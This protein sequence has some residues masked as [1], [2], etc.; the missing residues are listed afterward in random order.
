MRPKCEE[1]AV[2]SVCSKSFEHMAVN[3]YFCLKRHIKLHEKVQS[4]TERP[5]QLSLVSIEQPDFSLLFQNLDGIQNVL[6]ILKTIHLESNFNVVVPNLTTKK[7]FIV[8]EGK[9]KSVSLAGGAE[10]CVNALISHQDA[11]RQHL[12][13]ELLR[14]FNNVSNNTSIQNRLSCDFIEV[15]LN[16]SIQRRKEISRHLKNHF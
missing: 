4:N 6:D 9:V 3:R 13:G 14:K 8:S 7:V 12:T 15:L 10:L 2:C 5:S 16:D 11:M 1:P